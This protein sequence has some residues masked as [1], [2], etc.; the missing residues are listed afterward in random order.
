MRD[1]ADGRGVEI[2]RRVGGAT[3]WSAIDALEAFD[4]ESRGD[5]ERLRWAVSGAFVIHLLILLTRIPGLATVVAPPAPPRE[6]I[7]LKTYRFE[8]PAPPRSAQREPRHVRI[9]IPDPTPDEVE[10]VRPLAVEPPRLELPLDDGFLAIPEALPAPTDEAA[11]I[12]F[13]GEI[14]APRKLAAPMPAYSEIARRARRQGVVVVRATIDRDGR[15]VAARVEKGLGFGLD[16]ATLD[17]V[18]RWTFEPATL[19]GRPVAVFYYLTV[20]FELQS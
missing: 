3:S 20:R 12:P 5:R 7:P 15:V 11:P 9:P 16:E 13:G 4:A 17:A 2:R 6:P 10:P 18:R 8:P 14:V 19:H 1:A